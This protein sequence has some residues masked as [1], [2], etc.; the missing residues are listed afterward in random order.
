MNR[1]ILFLSFVFCF[2]VQLYSQPYKDS[3]LPVDIRVDDLLGRMTLEEKIAQIR[4]IHSWDI[5]NDQELD[6][7][8]LQKLAGDVAWGFVEGFPLTGENCR[9]HMRRIQ[10]YM[11]NKTRLGIPVFTIAEALHGSVHEGSTIYPQNIAL[12]ATF[13][14]SLAY[15]K[16]SKISEDL[17]YQGIRQIL[18]PCCGCGA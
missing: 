14:P 6:E 18:A 16:A 9:L 15:D 4:H 7:E 12:G 1:L 17:H 2:L 3:R 10:E 5:F 11:V 13:N 8:K